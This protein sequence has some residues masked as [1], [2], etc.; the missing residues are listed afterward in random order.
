[1][2]K[3]LKSALIDTREFVKLQLVN[4]APSLMKPS[5]FRMLGQLTFQ[6]ENDFEPELIFITELVEKNTAVIDVG[7]NLGWYLYQFEKANHFHPLIGFEPFPQL[8]KRL[9]KL[10][11]KA[12]I[13]DRAVSDVN[14]SKQLKT[15]VIGQ[16]LNNF[17][18]TLEKIVEEN[19][20]GAIFNTVPSIT[21]DDFSRENKL[22][23][24][25]FI[26]VDVEGHERAV[27]GGAWKLI[28]QS[29]P[30]LMIEI[31]QRHHEGWDIRNLFQEIISKGYAGYFFH[32]REKIF[33]PV[34][35]F[36][37]DLHQNMRRYVYRDYIN[38]FLFFSLNRDVSELFRSI[39]MRARNAA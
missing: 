7:A 8:F 20:T 13:Y 4:I 2:E 17:R 10:F 33:L 30:T 34:Q 23:Q 15:P 14:S 11:P 28:E 32:K 16:R 18:S 3:S 39:E 31:E 6:S 38:N 9:Q 12:M 21:L 29:K 26:K 35:Q 5:E 24:V 25:G 37:A 22:S 27:L 19:E 36:S 1:M